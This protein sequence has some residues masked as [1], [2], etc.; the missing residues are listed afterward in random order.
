MT[1]HP[2]NL[3]GLNA[4][5]SA[6]KQMRAGKA[7]SNFFKR[8]RHQETCRSTQEKIKTLGQNEFAYRCEHLRK[9]NQTCVSD[10]T[11]GNKWQCDIGETEWSHCEARVRTLASHCG[12][13]LYCRASR[14]GMHSESTHWRGHPSLIVSVI[15]SRPRKATEK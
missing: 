7:S 2:H 14:P 4:R 12:Q 1:G 5:P 8:L 10:Q 11:L 6:T 15:R 13:W 3:N 9:R